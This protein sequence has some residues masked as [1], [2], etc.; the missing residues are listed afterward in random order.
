MISYK[1]DRE[2]NLTRETVPEI[3]AG[4]SRA[5]VAGPLAR[6]VPA[7]AGAG[8]AGPA[9]DHAGTGLAG[10]ATDL[11]HAGVGL[12]RAGAGL[13]RRRVVDYC[14]VTTAL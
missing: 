13:T 1:N 12:T 2:E 4:R 5:A 11:A 7:R 14:R 3:A 6:P 10:A 8:L 9:T